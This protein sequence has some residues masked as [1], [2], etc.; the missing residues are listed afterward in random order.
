MTVIG[1]TNVPSQYVTDVQNAAKASGLPA[2]VVAAQI[3]LESAFNPS[4]VSPTGAQGI[5]QFEPGTWA[6]WGS[7]S[8]FNVSDAFTAYAKYMASLLGQEKG[9]IEDALAA[10]NAG[11]A[12]I[13]AGLGYA[14]SILKAAGEPYTATAGGGQGVGG[15]LGDL[16]GLTGIVSGLGSIAQEF[17]GMARVLTWLTLPSNW[18]RIFAGLFGG[19]ALGVGIYLIGKE[20]KAA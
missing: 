10:Y 15:V 14:Q 12:N 7:G 8:P 1:G 17:E 11:P 20:A 19:A 4:A 6:T 18:T 9:S 13:P 16:T 5:A 3:N 2:S